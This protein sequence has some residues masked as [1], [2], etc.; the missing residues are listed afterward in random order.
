MTLFSQKYFIIYVIL[1]SDGYFKKKQNTSQPG[2]YLAVH[3]I[4][5]ILYYIYI[6]LSKE[7]QDT[8]F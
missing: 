4:F 3:F 2:G 6:L 1:V 8:Y 7:W 5:Y